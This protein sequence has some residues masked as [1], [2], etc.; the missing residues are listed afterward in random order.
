MNMFNGLFKWVFHIGN[1]L[2]KLM[3]L[4]LLWAVFTLLGLIAFGLFPATAGVF[5]VARKWME[6]GEDTLIFK[7]FINVYKSTFIQI[8]GLG[9]VMV[10]IGAFLTYDFILSREF[11]GS[12]IIHI[13]L[14][15]FSVL[16]ILVLCYLFPVFVRYD[17]QFFLYFKQ[18]F[19]VVLARPVESIGMLIC[20]ILLYYL[21]ILLPVLFVMAGSSI[22]AFLLMALAYRSFTKIEERKA[23]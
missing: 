21:L 12:M 10:G 5:A 6:E 23:N 18:T 2:F 7:T 15:F 8:N 16:F 22:I 19:L 11:V 3:Y 4:H 17:L 13:L 20:L 1:W 14:L 9:Y